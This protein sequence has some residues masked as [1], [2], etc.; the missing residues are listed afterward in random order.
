MTGSPLKADFD[1]DEVFDTSYYSGEEAGGRPSRRGPSLRGLETVQARTL[2][3][4]LNT[5]PAIQDTEAWVLC[6]A[7]DNLQEFFTTFLQ[8]FYFITDTLPVEGCTV[9]YLTS[10]LWNR[11]RRNRNFLTSG[12]GTV[13]NYGSGTGTRYKIM[14]LIT[15][16]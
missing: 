7:T 8:G 15:F 5:A 12:T 14:C 4:R 2:L 1:P 10:A 11:N 6:S 13:I 9:R 3:S 16:I